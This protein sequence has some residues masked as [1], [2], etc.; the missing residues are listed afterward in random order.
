MRTFQ[1]GKTT[2]TISSERRLRNHTLVRARTEAMAI[3]GQ[4]I[5]H[6]SSH[7]CISH[8]Y[9]PKRGPTLFSHPR[10]L[11]LTYEKNKGFY[12]VKFQPW[13]FNKYFIFHYACFK[14]SA[15]QKSK[16]EQVLVWRSFFVFE[17]EEWR[18]I[19]G[20]KTFFN[21]PNIM[22]DKIPKMSVKGFIV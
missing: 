5:L 15:V 8:P 1:C 2:T 22:H 12:I 9:I 7:H 17:I 10:R 4:T 19:Y 13:T 20:S 11:R 14:D 16:L 18:S 6:S 21:D 3:P